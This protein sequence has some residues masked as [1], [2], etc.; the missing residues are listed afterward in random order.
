[1]ANYFCQFSCLLDVGSSESADHADAIRGELAAELD[2]HEGAAL[3]F[4]MEIDHETGPGALWIYSDEYG[5][6]EH[7][8]RFV[9]RCAEAFDLKG[10]WGFCWSLTC[11]KPRIDAFGGG[12]LVLDL[13]TREAVASVDCTDW[14]A[15]RMVEGGE[16][17]EHRQREA[18][19]GNGPQS[20]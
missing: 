4:E 8:T 20:E 17:A 9:L 16:L 14:L 3:G 18:V 19:R 15:H 13:T 5:E 10:A 6:P 12:G 7:V 1:M 2:R 11:S